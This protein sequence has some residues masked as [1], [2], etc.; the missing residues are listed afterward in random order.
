MNPSTWRTVLY[1]GTLVLVAAGGC[2]LAWQCLSKSREPGSL[3]FKWIISAGLL[4]LPFLIFP[5]VPRSWILVVWILPATAIGMMWVPSIGA[6]LASLITGSMDGGDV[7]MDAQAFYSV[8]ET[9]RRNGHPQ[10]AV[11]L[12]R[13]ELEKFPADFAGVMLLASI[14]AEDLK[15]LPGAQLALERW[16]EG[17]AVTPQGKVSALTA[18]ADWHLQCAQDPEAARLALERIGKEFPNTPFSHQAAQRLAHLPTVEHLMAAGKPTL[19]NLR[20]GEKDLGL[21]QGYAGPVAPSP[22]LD[23]L[24]EEYVKQLEKYPA[25]VATREKLA[26]LYAEHFHRLDLAVDQ[27]EQLI[28]FPNETPRHVVGWLNLLADLQIRVGKDLAGAEATLRRVI[29]EFPNSA[30]AEPAIARLASL[31]GEMKGSHIAPLKTM[32]RYEKNLGLK[33]A[34]G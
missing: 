11:A 9:K 13:K 2:F 10:E 27:L 26:V 12:V 23:A 25:D 19:V 22:D 34:K 3:I 7:P 8:A 31:Q 33:K 6:M 32:G 5:H 29:E 20:P 21:R 1:L 18:L 4:G 17:P 16:M 30:L 15:D 14:L 28:A 24:A